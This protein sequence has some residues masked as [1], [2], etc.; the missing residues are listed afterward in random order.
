[1]IKIQKGIITAENNSGNP[2]IFDSLKKI[3]K[4]SGIIFFGMIL[5][6][7][8][9]LLARIFIARWSSPES[10]GLFSLGLGLTAIFGGIATLGLPQGTTRY[11]A[12]YRAKNDFLS[13]RKVLFSSI[14]MSSISGLTFALILYIGSDF[15]AVTFLHNT[16]LSV[17]LK[18]FSIGV[19]FI[20][21]VNIFI[22]IFR[23]FEKFETKAYFD[24]IFR[25]L[26]FL[27][28]VSFFLNIGLSFTSVMWAYV[29]ALIFTF[30]AMVLFMIKKK[31]IPN[32]TKSLKNMY[33]ISPYLIQKELIMYS[34]PVLGTGILGI[35]FARTDTLM[36]GYFRSPTIVGYY[37]AASPITH[38]VT[39]VM[40]A[41]A[42]TSL[43]IFSELYSK[44]SLEEMRRMYKIIT[45]WGIISSFVF[46]LFIYA[47]PGTILKS[48]FG[49]QYIK[50]SAPLQILVLA[51]F[52]LTMMGPT[53]VVLQALGKTKFIMWTTLIGLAINI[54]LNFYLIPQLGMIGAAVA[55]LL[56]RN[57]IILLQLIE[58]KRSFNLNPIDDKYLKT[59]LISAIMLL[60]LN[61]ISRTISASII[62]VML[63]ASIC[64]PLYA[65][66]IYL[67]NGFCLEDI[68]ILK[69]AKNRMRMLL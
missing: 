37:N 58:L 24:D 11:I 55:Y 15:L 21:L 9:G 44:G 2:L 64:I 10:Y 7:L 40:S 53:D 46:F 35:I 62:T 51:V 32:A 12:Y 1:M 39:I 65:F 50:A 14:Q 42:F 18:I 66:L 60:A 4:G 8:F 49:V 38:L 59:M 33:F 47:F 34:L 13:V 28:M 45:K 57:T 30:T 67:L 3:G 43:P 68:V 52:L 23:G 25:S 31:V 17:Y 48:L 19:A 61:I 6:M 16:Q 22:A 26:L 27:I 5:G 36:L 54:M 63:I 29:L 56:G 69:G 41:I 20:V